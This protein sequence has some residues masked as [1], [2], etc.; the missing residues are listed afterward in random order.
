ML[1]L[2]VGSRSRKG[3]SG[4]GGRDATLGDMGLLVVKVTQRRHR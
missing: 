3:N 1:R 4:G 2:Q